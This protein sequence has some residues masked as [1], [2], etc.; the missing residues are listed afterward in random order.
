MDLQFNDKVPL[1]VRQRALEHV[2]KA[3]AARIAAAL[4]TLEAS[5]ALERTG[6][7]GEGVFNAARF[8]T[9]DYEVSN[10]YAKALVDEFNEAMAEGIRWAQEIEREKDEREARTVASAAPA[11]TG[12]SPEEMPF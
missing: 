4:T 2:L 3:K 9:G 12:V 11:S 6:G 10:Q 1:G 7:D 8:A 5:K